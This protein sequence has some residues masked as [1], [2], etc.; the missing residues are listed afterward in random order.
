MEG[1]KETKQLFAFL[2][3]RHVESIMK[4][5][6]M[7]VISSGPVGKAKNYTHFVS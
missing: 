2:M 7:T 4:M 5:S 6:E 1:T 3:Q